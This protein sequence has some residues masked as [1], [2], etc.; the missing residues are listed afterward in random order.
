MFKLHFSNNA[1]NEGLRYIINGSIATIIDLGIFHY[2][3][4][5]GSDYYL[6][7]V[8]AF[9]AG[10]IFSYLGSILFVF[11]NYIREPIEEEIAIFSLI[12]LVGF[13]LNILSGL[14]ITETDIIADTSISGR[15]AKIFASLSIMFF[16]A[17][18]KKTFLFNKI[19]VLK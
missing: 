19:K 1:R 18:A 11:K 7:A 6:I 10:A 17:L 15:L 9:L 3:Y 5:P 13:M 16:N 14:I 4:N 8:I 2:L 12:C